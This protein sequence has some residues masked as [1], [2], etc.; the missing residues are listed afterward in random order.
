M[1]SGTETAA[2]RT[3]SVRFGAVSQGHPRDVSLDDW[4]C[5]VYCHQPR[6]GPGGVLIRAMAGV[7]VSKMSGVIAL[8]LGAGRAAP[9]RL[10]VP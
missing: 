5:D 8:G 7:I 6:P 9:C 1:V 2:L 3:I 10:L 4:T